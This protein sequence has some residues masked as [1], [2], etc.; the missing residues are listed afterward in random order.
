MKMFTAAIFEVLGSRDS[1]G[2]HPV[3][4]EQVGKDC[5]RCTRCTQHGVECSLQK[6]RTR[7]THSNIDL[8]KT[9]LTGKRRKMN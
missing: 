3:H 6:Q 2:I 8:K 4:R 7:H 5:G 9:V 1:L